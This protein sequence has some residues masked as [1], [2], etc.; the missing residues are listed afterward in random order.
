MIVQKALLLE[1]TIEIIRYFMCFIKVA[2]NSK[3]SGD[4]ANRDVDD[5]EGGSSDPI[6]PSQSSSDM[7]S[8]D[9]SMS[10]ELSA[11]V[12]ALTHVVSGQGSAGGDSMS[13][14]PSFS[15]RDHAI[16]SVDSPNSSSSSG[17][18]VGQKRVRDQQQSANQFQEHF[19]QRFYGSFADFRGGES[20]SSSS[21]VKEEVITQQPTTTTTTTVTAPIPTASAATTAQNPALEMNQ[22]EQTGERRRKYRGV[23]QRPWGKW[24]A[25][26][27]DPHKAARVWLG[28]FDTAEAAARAYDEAALRFRGNRAKL[29]FPENVRLIP[30]QQQLRPATQLTIQNSPTNQFTI[31]QQPPR[32][33]HHQFQLPDPTA[34]RDYWQYSQLLQ[35]NVPQPRQNLLQQM[36]NASTMGSLHS[37]STLN[38][39]SSSSAT[40]P[41]LFPNQSSGYL[42][43]RQPGGQN[44]DDQ[45]DFPVNPQSWPGQDQFPP[46]EN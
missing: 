23:R 42:D 41:L 30:Q 22:F 19:P 39:S 26:I 4:H 44:Q 21:K 14:Q 20:S 33:P 46:P 8:L 37:Q 12:T 35:S 40:N 16:F 45:E 3:D 11:M 28:T 25:E 7:F 27:R 17:S 24:A 31:H 1:I 38:L 2:N 5:G 36:F 15:A 43:F 9:Y 29:N 34:A 18:F 10:G 32:M 13:L 6:Y